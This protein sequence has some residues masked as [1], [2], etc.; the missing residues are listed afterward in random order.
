[1]TEQ[2]QYEK[3]LT[4]L[5]QD[6]FRSIELELGGQMVDVDL[7]PDHYDYALKKAFQDYRQLSSNSV[8]ESYAFLTLVKDQNEYYLPNEIISVRQVFRRTIGS[9]SNS[10]TTNFEPFEAGYMNM[11][12]L[13][14]G[15]VGG[16]A[17]YEFFAQY[18]ELSSRMFGGF[19]NYHFNTSTKKL[20]IMRRPRGEDESV[21]LWV[22][23]HKPDLTILRDTYSYPW[24]RD[25]TAALCKRAL[26]EARS[27]FATIVGPQGGTSL[28]GDALK[29]EAQTE[30]ER[31]K[32]DIKMYVDG[33]Q[34]LGFIIG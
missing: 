15:R 23:N 13:Q 17:S 34:P 18:Q 4:D 31:L 10:S 32:E 22:F 33:G 7:D 24:I 12:L 20:T 11:Y 3:A 16:L 19:I 26:G 14:S 5:K 27:K 29:Q 25:Y 8:E 9:T 28:N 30:I 1:M 6:L 2:D 21:L